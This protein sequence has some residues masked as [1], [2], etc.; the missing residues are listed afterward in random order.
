MYQRGEN[1]VDSSA[2]HSPEDRKQ[3]PWLVVVRG[4][5]PETF[6]ASLSRTI[7]GIQTSIPKYLE[8]RFIQINFGNFKQLFVLV[9]YHENR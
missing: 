4:L 9:A 7:T 1:V 2:N 6:K 5:W 8:S 3:M